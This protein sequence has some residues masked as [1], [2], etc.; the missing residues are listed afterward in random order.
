MKLKQFIIMLTLS[1]WSFSA[2]S[3][4]F[5]ST[6]DSENYKVYINNNTLHAKSYTPAPC[7]DIKDKTVRCTIRVQ[8]DGIFNYYATHD[9]SVKSCKRTAG[10]ALK[11]DN[12]DSVSYTYINNLEQ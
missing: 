4:I 5:Y 7:I 12:G 11:K 8:K 6:C 3:G 9:N 10:A 2:S 1:L